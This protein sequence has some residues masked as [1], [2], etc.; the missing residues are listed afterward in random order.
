MD[1]FRK[2][3]RRHGAD[4]AIAKLSLRQMRQP[5]VPPPVD[6]RELRARLGM[7]Q[8]HFARRFGFPV[9]TLRHGERGNRTPAGTARVLLYVIAREPVLVL[10]VLSREPL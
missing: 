2:E 5:R 7:S 6:V 9:A 4:L 10:R 8:E 3:L 1:K